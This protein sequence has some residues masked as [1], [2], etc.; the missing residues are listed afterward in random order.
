MFGPGGPSGELEV[1]LRSCPRCAGRCLTWRRIR[2]EVRGMEGA[3]FPEPLVEALRERLTEAAAKG[4]DGSPAPARP[5]PESSG[6]RKAVLVVGA[7]VLLIAVT[8]ATLALFGGEREPV[9]FA[10]RLRHSEGSVQV[11]PAGASGWR[12]AD[13]DEGLMPG[14]VLRAEADGRAHVA[15]EGVQWWLDRFS[16]FGVG[17][18]GMAELMQGRVLV[19]ADGTPGAPARVLSTR[20]SMDCEQGAFTALLSAQRLRVACVEGTTVLGVG[21]VEVTLS[22]GSCAMLTGDGVCGAVRR[23]R[24]GDLTH[25]LK[26][27][28]SAGEGGL[29]ARQLASVPVDRDEPVLPEGVRLETLALD[30]RVRGPLATVQVAARLRNEGPEPWSGELA[31]SDVIL[32]PPL[33]EASAAV[34]V[35]AGEARECVSVAVCLLRLRHGWFSLGLNPQVWS[36]GAIERMEMNLDA[37]ATGGF[38]QLNCPTHGL[39]ARRENEVRWSWEGRD[40][41]SSRPVVFEFSLRGHDT[42]DSLLLA[43]GEDAWAAVAWLPDARK[44]DWFDR[45]SEVVIA[46]DASADFGPGGRYYAQE[47]LEATLGALPVGSR[48]ALAAYD[49]Q[50]RVAPDPFERHFPARVENMLA[51]L[52]QL[53]EAE[54]EPAGDFLSSVLAL[55]SGGEADRVLILVTGGDEPAEPA[56][57]GAGE[58]RDGLHVLVLQCGVDAPGPRWRELCAATDGVAFALPGAMTGR[59]AAADFVANLPWPGLGEARLEVTGDGAGTLFPALA[60]FADQP[61]AAL[62]EVPPE[63]AAGRFTAA[64]ADERLERDF[65]VG[66][67]AAALE[68]QAGRRLVDALRRAASR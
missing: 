41:P 50:L 58:L 36:A 57:R 65:E 30:L 68:G 18:A 37:A 19:R 60:N 1:H 12:A 23:A 11:R 38:K 40:V 43:D 44:K 45:A 4:P 55:A 42:V 9:P 2:D 64:T 59:L 14:A 47:A 61:V 63:G 62:V 8:L 48:T 52:W 35:P 7:L 24:R 67:A 39:R 54:E 20:G 16:A 51:A 17:E 13:P 53:E 34:E 31:A 10:A 49:G 32:P 25:W 26:G 28:G 6:V 33:A 27:F 3:P 66:R 29:S 21:E 15:S 5:E 22:E 46:F 56:V